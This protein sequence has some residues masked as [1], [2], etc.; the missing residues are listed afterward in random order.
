MPGE[1]SLSGGGS[2][3]WLCQASGAASD[4][5]NIAKKGSYSTFLTKYKTTRE[6]IQN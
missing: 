3:Y 1:L 4:G 5:Q 6:L 2:D